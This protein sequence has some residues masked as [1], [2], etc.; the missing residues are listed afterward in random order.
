MNASRQLGIAIG[1]LLVLSCVGTDAHAV[2]HIHDTGRTLLVNSQTW[3]GG[4][5][6]LTNVD[7]VNAPLPFS[8]LLWKGFL[9]LRFQYGDSNYVTLHGP[10][11]D[12]GRV[13][14]LYTSSFDTLLDTVGGTYTID[15]CA[16]HDSLD[17]FK[18][19]CEF[20][21]NSSRS[22][23]SAYDIYGRVA[24]ADSASPRTPLIRLTQS[25]KSLLCGNR[26]CIG[27]NYVV[28]RAEGTDW[29]QF[30]D[31][32]AVMF[33]DFDLRDDY[34]L[35]DSAFVTDDTLIGMYDPTVREAIS[36]VP[37]IHGRGPGAN[38]TTHE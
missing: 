37:Y 30:H 2:D 13:P 23:V 1:A 32:Q 22:V 24:G 6:E 19:P 15:N 3:P 35:N 10:A 9:A 11:H 25:V 36:I 20:P 34:G 7:S 33:W 31:A 18:C 14:A 21:E 4:F 17:T 16:H 12:F 27:V 29:A 5:V 26:H 8:D 38:D 28:Q